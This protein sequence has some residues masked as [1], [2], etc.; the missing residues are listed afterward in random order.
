M[1]DKDEGTGNDTETERSLQKLSYQNEN[2]DLR[3]TCLEAQF[4]T[5]TQVTGLTAP[6]GASGSSAPQGASGSN[7]V[8]FL[9]FDAGT[10]QEAYRRIKDSVQGIKLPPEE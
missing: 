7:S 4:L 5:G 1:T 9:E 2:I 8:E 3:T 6:Q 10:V